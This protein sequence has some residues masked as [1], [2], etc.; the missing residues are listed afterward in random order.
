MLSLF[1]RTWY[2]SPWRQLR[3]MQRR[4]DRLFGEFL[5]PLAPAFPPVNVYTNDEGAVITAEVP[6]VEA[7]DLDV[8]VSG[9]TVTI[10]GERKAEDVGE[11]ARWHRQERRFGSFSRQIEMPFTIDPDSVEA[12]CRD[13]VLEVRLRRVESEKPRKIPVQG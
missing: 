2:G 3:E 10:R 4:M 7:D 12:S 8:S 13:G 11:D 9:Q 5:R 6:G 1:D